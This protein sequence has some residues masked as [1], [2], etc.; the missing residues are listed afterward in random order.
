MKNVPDRCVS[1]NCEEG[2]FCRGGTC[3]DSCAEISCPLEQSC[4]DGECRP[5]PCGGVSCPDG[6][7]CV[8]GDCAADACTGVSCPQNQRRVDG[9]CRYDTCDQIECPPGQA[10][11]IDQNGNQQCVFENQ[12][13]GRAP[14]LEPNPGMNNQGMPLGGVSA[15]PI[16]PNQPAATNSGDGNTPFNPTMG[17]GGAAANGAEEE[18]PA[19]DVIVTCPNGRHLQRLGLLSSLCLPSGPDVVDASERLQ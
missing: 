11:S 13:E 4:E 14:E 9:M 3:I 19:E 12:P 6:Q 2:Q 10:C 7:A 18:T 8:A 5:D 15:T 1:A 17:M 16:N